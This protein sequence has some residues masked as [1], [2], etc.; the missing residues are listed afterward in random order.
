MNTAFFSI[1]AYEKSFLDAANTDGRHVFTYFETRLTPETARLARGYEVVCAFVNDHLDAEVLGILH[2]AEV[3]FLVLRCAGFNHVDLET[4]DR[5]GLPVARV[6]AYSPYSVAEYT[7]ALM[8]D[9][10]RKIHRAFQ[11]V[12]EGN[13]EL[14]GLMG[15]DMHGLTAGIVGTGRIGLGVC[16]ILSSFGLKL[17]AFDPRPNDKA[18]TL[19]ISYV[20]LEEL[21]SCS[22]IVTLHCPLTPLTHHLINAT[23]VRQMKTGVMLINTSRGAVIDT[24]AVI[25][26]LKSGKIGYLGLDVYEEEEN[27]FFRDLSNTVIQ[28]DVFSRLLTFP[29]VLITGH[30]AFF[31]RNAMEAIARITL[32][33]LDEFKSAGTCANRITTESHH[34]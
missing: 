33:N 19:G 14:G 27:L 8:L 4:A 20:P 26:G 15:F 29:N 22:D 18:S 9:L 24:P 2:A 1:K 12:R 17:L 16:R 6:P 3:R 23:T 32:Q 30:Q 10:N 13:F 31:T 34:R 11:R 21:L 7:V 5:L 25:D 28:D